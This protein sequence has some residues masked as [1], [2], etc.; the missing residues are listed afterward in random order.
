[1]LAARALGWKNAGSH[2]KAIARRFA[3]RRPRAARERDYAAWRRAVEGVR[4]VARLT[5]AAAPARPKRSA[6]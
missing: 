5:T 6:R 3:P 1:L 4:A 2:A